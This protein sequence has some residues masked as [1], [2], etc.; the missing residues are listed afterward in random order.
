MR[1]YSWLCPIFV[2]LLSITSIQAGGGA[3]IGAE[4][5]DDS[6]ELSGRDRVVSDRP[7]FGSTPP[8]PANFGAPPTGPSSCSI[9]DDGVGGWVVGQNGCIEGLPGNWIPEDAPQPGEPA[10]DAPAAEPEPIVITA[11]DLQR[12]P[13]NAGEIATQ[14][15]SGWVLVNVETIAM[16][17]AGSH[18]LTTTVLD[19]PVRVHVTPVD[20]TWDFGDGSPP[21]VTT[22]PGAPYPHHTVA[23]VY[24]RATDTATIT[25]TTRWAGQF[26]V[27]GGG[28]QPVAGTATTTQTS[29]PFEVRTAKTSLEAGQASPGR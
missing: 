28:W 20:Y 14:P 18:D 3:G 17:T 24:T 22:A 13:I 5:E 27:D 9:Y 11:A 12:L 2:G 23:H 29:A 26:Q 6:I 15:A 10:P 4:A 25:L 19:T 16:T 8:A 1:T 21:L 7:R